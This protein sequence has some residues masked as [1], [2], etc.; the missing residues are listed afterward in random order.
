MAQGLKWV[1]ITGC[2]KGLGRALAQGFAAAGWGVAGCAR[3]AA[4]LATLSDELGEPHRFTVVDV[5]DAPTVLGWAAE[6]K[7]AG[8]RPQLVIANAAVITAE[9]ALW[10]LQPD[11][12]AQLFAININGVAFTAQAFVPGLLELGQGTFVAMSS[13]WGR[14]TS[15]GVAPYCASKFAVEGMMQALAQELPR[16]IAA[17]AV[18][19]GVIDTEMLQEVW[20]RSAHAYEAPAAW[21]KRA[22]PYLISLGPPDSGQPGTVP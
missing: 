6:L 16:K 22:V 13:G 14:S 1:A 15:P 3:T 7:R 10:E 17:V 12:V 21:A 11:E 4:A 5:A 2:S 8:I 18:N 20:G 19:P 9:R